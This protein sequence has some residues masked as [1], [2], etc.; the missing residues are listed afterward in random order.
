MMSSRSRRPASR[1]LTGTFALTTVL[2]A[3]S[4][5]A[6]FAQETGSAPSHRG[7]SLPECFS[8]D[9][10]DCGQLFDDFAYTGNQDPD[11]EANGWYLRDGSG[12]PGQSGATWT[13]DNIGFSSSG[14][15]TSMQL[16]TA[17]DGT[18]A[19]TTQAEIGRVSENA[20]AGTYSAR[21]K[22]SDSPASGT[23]GDHV[24]QTFFAISSPPDCDPTYS[25]TDFSEYLPNGGYGETR[26]FNSQS[27]WA[28][29]G[30]GCESDFVESDQYESL[31]GWHTIMATVADGTVTYF[32]DGE[33]VGTASGAYYPRRNMSIAFNNWTLDLTGHAGTGRSVWS[34]SVDYVYYAENRELTPAQVE[35]AVGAHRAS[36][37]TF[38]DTVGRSE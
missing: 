23:D 7:S 33:V 36:G 4:A 38:V 14:G 9:P 15:V 26:T 8:S 20:F 19:G 17:T 1:I 32:V 34:E 11:L 18:A 13:S 16:T 2:V 24:V 22:F 6:T 31:A 5:T 10:S 21:I 27:T 29:T 25:E 3:G 37:T 35:E 12:G 28:L 30:D